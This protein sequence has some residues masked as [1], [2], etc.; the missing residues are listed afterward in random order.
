[1][2]IDGVKSVFFGEDF[3]CL[4]CLCLIHFHNFQIFTFHF[5]YYILFMCFGVK[6]KKISWKF[7]LKG[8]L[9]WKHSPSDIPTPSGV[10]RVRRQTMGRP[11]SRHWSRSLRFGP[12]HGLMK[13]SKFYI[14][15]RNFIAQKSHNF[16]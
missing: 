6:Y 11:S 2:R 5:I 16:V 10:T 12:V 9:L 14:K 7:K 4:F 8:E 15:F 3:V 13:T 1:M